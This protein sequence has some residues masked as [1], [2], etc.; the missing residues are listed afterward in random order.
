MDFMTPMG[1]VVLSTMGSLAQ[2]YSDNLSFETKKGKRERKEQGLFNGVLPFGAM[3]GTDGVPVPHPETH[4]GLQLAF[5]LA[6]SGKTDREI[7]RAPNAEGYGTTGN[8]GANP[9]SKDTVRAMPRNRFYLDDLPDGQGGWIPGKHVALI[10]LRMFDLAQSARLRNVTR[11]RRVRTETRSPWALSGLATCVC[12]ATM[13]AYGHASGRQQ[14]RCSRRTQTKN[15]DAPT[16]YAEIVEE[17][18][19]QFLRGFAAPE[20][21]RARLIAAWKERQHARPSAAAEREA[22]NRKL[23]RLRVLF[24]DGDLDETEYRTQRAAV[25]EQ[26]ALL[27]A[28][29]NTATPDIAERLAAYLADVALAWQVATPEERNRLARELFNAVRIENRTAVEVTPRLELLP[30]FAT[31]ASDS[32]SVMTYGRKRRASVAPIRHFPDAAIILSAFP[33][34]L[35]RYTEPRP[36]K[37]SAAQINAIVSAV[38]SG[39]TLRDVAVDFGVSA[40]RVGQL[41]RERKTSAIAVGGHAVKRQQLAGLS[42]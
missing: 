22:L 25:A 16:F 2:F 31:L 33:L 10:D 13:T 21:D 18:I 32:S 7:A 39:R 1:R 35:P 27:P 42:E 34:E 40:A 6:A 14:V 4:A 5:Q 11:P 28:D 37:L 29:D 15:C 23:A 30:F 38:V 17:Q 19:G 8:R 12:G 41:A 3:K 36:S 26:L 20:S 24:L 9:F